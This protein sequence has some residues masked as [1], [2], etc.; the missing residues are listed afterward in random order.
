MTQFKIINKEFQEA[1]DIFEEVEKLTELGIAGKLEA[2][3]ENGNIYKL[4]NG[5]S[6]MPR[7]EALKITIGGQ[8][9]NH[10]KIYYPVE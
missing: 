7:V 2:I 3:D 9:T 6:E 1:K 10:I 4:K 8:T 5:G